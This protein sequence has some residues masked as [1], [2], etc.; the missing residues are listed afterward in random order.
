MM[1][2]NAFNGELMANAVPHVFLYVSRIKGKNMSSDDDL[3]YLTDDEF[4]EM[5]E[6]L[7][8]YLQEKKKNKFL[9]IITLSKKRKI[10]FLYVDVYI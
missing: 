6:K 9:K 3:R 2:C 4:N 8:P 10:S 7:K 1:N 5:Y